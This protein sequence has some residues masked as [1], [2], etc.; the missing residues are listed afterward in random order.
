MVLAKLAK[1][2]D[3]KLLT[4]QNTCTGKKTYKTKKLDRHVTNFH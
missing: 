1:I 2:W 3:L 4:Q